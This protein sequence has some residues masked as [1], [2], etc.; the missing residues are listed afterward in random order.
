MKFKLLIVLVVSSLLIYD[1]AYASPGRT[2]KFG[3]HTQSSTGEYHCHGGVSTAVVVVFVVVVA[4]VGVFWYYKTDGGK[5]PT[6][7]GCLFD[8]EFGT[9]H[10]YNSLNQTPLLQSRRVFRLPTI[11][12]DRENEN[13]GWRMEATYSFSF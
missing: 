11:K 7:S 10:L 4:L 2:D 8:S 3:C 13:E 9:N 12:F 6:K 1:F 5:K